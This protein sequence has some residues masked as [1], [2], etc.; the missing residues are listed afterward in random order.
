MFSKRKLRG[1]PTFAT[2]VLGLFGTQTLASNY[3][4]FF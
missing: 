3:S 4:E 2:V 1:R